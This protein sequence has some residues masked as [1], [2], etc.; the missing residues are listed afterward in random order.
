MVTVVAVETVVEIVEDAVNLTATLVFHV[1]SSVT[2]GS[3]SIHFQQILSFLSL[4]SFLKKEALFYLCHFW[5]FC[6]FATTEIE[7]NSQIHQ[8]DH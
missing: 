7:S 1:D 2:L 8:M 4:S 3:I 6:I 5:T